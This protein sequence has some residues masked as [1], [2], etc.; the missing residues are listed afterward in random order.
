MWLAVRVIDDPFDRSRVSTPQ[1]LQNS[2]DSGQHGGDLPFSLRG[3]SDSNRSHTPRSVGATPTP[4]THFRLIL[5]IL[6]FLPI[7]T[8]DEEKEEDEDE[9]RISNHQPQPKESHEI[10]DPSRPSP[11]PSAELSTQ[12]R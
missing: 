12:S 9:E 8:W 7:P 11:A 2:A 6:V 3:D 1:S 5:I 10:P 4:A